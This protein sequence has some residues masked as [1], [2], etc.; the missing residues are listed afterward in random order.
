LKVNSKEEIIDFYK[1]LYDQLNVILIGPYPPPFGGV[2]VHIQRLASLLE[3]HGKRVNVLNLGKRGNLKYLYIFLKLFFSQRSIIGIH[4]I[5]YKLSFV[6]RLV[7][8]FRRH[9]VLFVVHNPRTELFSKKAYKY[10]YL[11]LLKK[12]AVQFVREQIKELYIEKA[13]VKDKQSLVVFPA[14]LPPKLENEKIDKELVHYIESKKQLLLFYGVVHFRDN[15]DLYGIDMIVE[16]MSRLRKNYPDI[17]MIVLLGDQTSKGE[18]I[19]DLVTK[20]EIGDSIL[21]VDGKVEMWPLYKKSDILLRPTTSDGDAVSIR[22]A[23][24]FGTNVIASDCVERPDGVI[25]HKNR[26]VDDFYNKICTVLENKK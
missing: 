4:S 18:Y 16:V 24:L 15:T 6:V 26:D 5:D 20:H 3:E 10:S 9:K 21:F 2:S 8:F 23:L 19:M 7:V 13:L 1:S 12:A 25:L 11:K 17:G 22:E 14:F